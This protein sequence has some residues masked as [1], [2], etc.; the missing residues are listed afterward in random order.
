MMDRKP[1][2]LV[3]A[4]AQEEVVRSIC[5]CTEI[6]AV[7]NLGRARLNLDPVPVL[8]DMEEL[9]D[10]TA[11]GTCCFLRPFPA[12]NRRLPA[13]VRRKVHVL[14]AGPI[15]LSRLLFDQLC[16]S[17]AENH[18]RLSWGNRYRFSRLHQALHARVRNPGFGN[19][20]YLRQVRGGG[21]GLLSAWWSACEALDQART[22]LGA[23]LRE[24]LV[25]ASRQGSQ[26][27][28]V[29]TV[30][31]ANQSSAQLVIAPVHLP[32]NHD[33]TLLGS[34]GLLFSDGVSNSSPIVLENGIQLQPHTD[35]YPEPAWLAD[36]LG[37]LGGRDKPLPDWSTLNLNNRMLRAIRQ[38]LRKGQP[39]RV[40]LQGRN[41]RCWLTA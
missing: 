20:V 39:V 36:F 19:P 14:S 3:A 7:L 40:N 11:S 41:I 13:F 25:A 38:S 10:R 12:L 6:D 24:L 5:G 1:V 2:A 27:H 29:L 26:Y 33:I 28:A 15:P 4:A 16:E 21:Q 30:S 37:Q 9:L 32:I 31:A 18:V 34:G 22:L 35:Q 8:R 23:P 17:A